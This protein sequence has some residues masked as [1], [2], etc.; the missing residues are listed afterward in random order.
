MQKKSS[1]RTWIFV[2]TVILIAIFARSAGKLISDARHTF[3]AERYLMVDNGNLVFT[4]Q[5]WGSAPERSI[6]K[7]LKSPTL[8]ARTTGS[9]IEIFKDGKVFRHTAP[10]DNIIVSPKNQAVF[11]TQYENSSTTT[12]SGPPMVY[13]RLYMW[14]EKGG[15]ETPNAQFIGTSS[16]RLSADEQ[17]LLEQNYGAPGHEGMEV[18]DIKTKTTTPIKN[19]DF[20]SASIVDRDTALT[21]VKDPSSYDDAYGKLFRI[22]QKTGNKT[23]VLPEQLF[24]RITM[25]DG[26]IWALVKTNDAFQVVRLA[27]TLDRIVETIKVK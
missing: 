6:V 9:Q 15:F 24:G 16:P 22:D 25:F 1:V 2:F 4:K 18:Y 5:T 26:G 21:I 10:A 12:K 3:R 7:K 13:P 19:M 20:Y 23:P 17:I 11:F 27:P 8:T 14:T